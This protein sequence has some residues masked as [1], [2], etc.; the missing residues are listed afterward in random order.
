MTDC[1]LVLAVNPGNSSTKIGLFDPARQVFAVTVEHPA[2]A[3]GTGVDEQLAYRAAAIDTALAAHPVGEAGLAAVVGRGGLLKPVAGGTYRV[4]EAM[5]ADL[6]AQERGRHASNLGGLL[7]RRIADPLGIPAFV[8]DPVS[9]DEL[10]PVARVTG[11]PGVR[12]ESF[13]HAL[14]MRAVGRRTAAELGLAY[15]RARLV[16][17]HLGSGITL[18]AQAGGRMIDIS[19]SRQEG[20]LSPDRCGALPNLAVVGLCFDGA[21]TKDEVTARIFG[22]SG[23]SAL[24]GTRD[25]RQALRRAADG[26]EEAALV[27]SAMAYQV[28]KEIGALASVL[29][30]RVDAVV[31]TGGMAHA[32]ELTDDIASRVGWIA[33]VRVVPGEEELPSLAQGAWRVLRGEEP[34]LDY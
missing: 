22:G 10:E 23:M 16:V 5:V 9:V 14:N 11:M 6:R 20:A 25:I 15:E 8:V 28:A 34:A 1:A 7:A 12:R 33:P 18:S 26:D 29:R 13:S 31:L 30:G 27:L 2:G 4:N 3:G 19:D 17:A 24:L 21:P 32:R